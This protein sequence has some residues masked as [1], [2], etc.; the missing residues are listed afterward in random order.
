MGHYRS[1]SSYQ[2]KDP[3]KLQR[4][5]QNLKSFNRG[6]PKGSR[7]KSKVLSEMTSMDIITFAEKHF[8]LSETRKPVVLLDWEKDIF[9][10][11]FYKPEQDRPTLALLGM[12]KKSGKSTLAAIVALWYLVTKPMS[13]IYILGP[14]L[15]QG[16]LVIFDKIRKAIRLNPYLNDT[17]KIFKDYIEN[18]YND[19]KIQ[20][21][22]CNKTAAGLNPDLVIFDELWQFTS[23]EAKRAIDEMTNV[24]TKHNLI[25]VVTY[26]GYESDE[27]GHLWRWYKQGIDIRE[28]QAEPDPQFYFLWRTDYEG[29]SWVTEAYLKRQQKRLRPNT[30]KRLHENQWTSGEEQFIDAKTIDVCTTTHNHVRGDTHNNPVVIGL[31]IGYKHDCTAIAAVGAVS[32]DT[33]C[34][35]DHEIWIPPEGEELNLEQSFERELLEWKQTHNIACVVFDPYQAVR[36]AQ[37]LSAKGIECVEFPQTLANLCAMAEVLQGLMKSRHL[38]LY[39]DSELR[40]HLLNAA[41]KESSRGWRIVKSNQAR[42]IDLTIALAMAC[43]VATEIL[44]HPEPAFIEVIGQYDIEGTSNEFYLL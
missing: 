8:Y 6:R 36:S 24:P 28:G 35:V 11:L 42:K 13:E 10:D 16:Q 22:P 41:V 9:K 14:D 38:W 37:R 17:C 43:K 4:Q 1:A 40:Q 15:Q 18:K 30:Y 3:K 19:A 44:L 32:A 29:V 7:S 21:L 2:S 27:D 12:P 26:A 25:L 5:L 39:D 31:D 34:L 23:V 20:V 33:L